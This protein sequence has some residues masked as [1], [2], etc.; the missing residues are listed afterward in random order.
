MSGSNDYTNPKRTIRLLDELVRL[1][2]NNEALHKVHHD[3]TSTIESNRDYCAKHEQFTSETNSDVQKRLEIVLHAF[4]GGNFS[5]HAR[6][7][8]V[9]LAL[10]EASIAEVP[11]K[12]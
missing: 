7:P 11:I 5:Y 4:W 10:A 3:V 12:R 2:F 8:K 6:T 9:F 1:G